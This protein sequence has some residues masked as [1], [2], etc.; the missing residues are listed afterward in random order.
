[1]DAMIAASIIVIAHDDDWC[2]DADCCEPST[3]NISATYAVLPKQR[4]ELSREWR[5][6]T[7]HSY[8]LILHT[9]GECLLWSEMREGDT[10]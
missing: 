4:G 6:S 3:P 10:K 5:M 8:R 7:N 1:V 2:L 9:N